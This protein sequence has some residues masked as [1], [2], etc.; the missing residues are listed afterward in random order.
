[1]VLLTTASG[2]ESNVMPMSWHSMLE[3]DPPLVG[4]VVSD[5]GHSHTLLSAS[6]ECVLNIPTEEIA[7]QVV[8]CGNTT[9]AKVDKFSKFGLTRSAAELVSA[10]LIAEC[11]AGLEC[12][13]SDTSMV[14]K[15]CYYVL[16]VVAAWVEAKV[17]NPRTLHHR[18]YGSFMI[19][20]PTIKLPSR[21]R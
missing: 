2:S 20:G 5:R 19:A 15:Y 21:M 14:S 12:R 4:C 6:Q 9:G 13:L 3:F 18:G 11:Y 8:G 1:V 10:P 7:A 16:E 17:K